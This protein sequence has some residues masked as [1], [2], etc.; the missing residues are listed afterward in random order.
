MNWCW[1]SSNSF[2]HYI[3]I[4]KMFLLWFISM[5]TCINWALK[6]KQLCILGIEPTWWWWINFLI[7]CWVHFANFLFRTFTFNFVRLTCN[8]SF[9]QKCVNVF[10]DS[11]NVQ[12]ESMH[13][14]K[15]KKPTKTSSIGNN[16]C[17]VIIK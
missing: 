8:F 7:Y 6:L 1:V 9:I 11:L 13:W 5:V 2:L 16:I 3:L 4:I 15:K 12:R 10:C 14:K 17:C